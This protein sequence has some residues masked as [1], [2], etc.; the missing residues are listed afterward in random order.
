MNLQHLLQS[1]PNRSCNAS[2]A[3]L[4]PGAGSWVPG[5]S[6]G[7]GGGPFCLTSYPVIREDTDVL[8]VRFWPADR[9]SVLVRSGTP[10]VMRLYLHTGTDSGGSLSISLQ[11]NQVPPACL[12][13]AWLSV[14][15]TRPAPHTTLGSSCADGLGH[16]VSLWGDGDCTG[17]GAGEG[18]VPGA[19][20]REMGCG[21][22]Q[23]GG[24]QPWRGHRGQWPAPGRAGTRARAQRGLSP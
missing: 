1:S 14:G 16:G 13:R 9:V 6:R 19:V 23:A 21:R 20:P 3:L 18:C 2:A 22:G 12:P 11:A 5:R 24:P 8:S 15:R 7:A 17:T 10:S 4:P